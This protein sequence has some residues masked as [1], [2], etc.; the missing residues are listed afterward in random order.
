MNR[1]AFVMNTAVMTVTSLLLRSLGIVFRIFISNRVGAEGMG[2][3]QLV[4]SVYVLGTA[5][6]AAGLTTAVTR[7]TAEA[8]ARK[9]P[10]TA[11]RILR[12]SVGL[13]ILFGCVSAGLL[14]GFS[15]P[16]ARLIGDRRAASSLAVS[17]IALPFIGISSCLKGYFMARRRAA[18]PSM[19]QIAEQLT[20]I[21]GILLLL[22]LA[23]DCPLEEACRIIIIGDALS[24]TVCC[25]WLTAA[26]ALDRRKLRKASPQ[27]PP[28]VKRGLL[29]PLLAIAVPLTAGRYLTTGLRTVEN[30]LVP[31]MLTRF[32][33]SDARSLAQFGAVKGM[34]L[35]LLF[36]P[37]AFLVTLSNLLVPELSDAHALG[38]KRQ[39]TKLTGQSLHITMLGAM[40]IG[41]LFTVFGRELGQYLYHDETVGL[42]LQILGPLAPV[43]YL[44]TVATGLLRGLGEQVRSLWYSAADS[45]LRLSLIP[46]L[47][48][49]F[50]ITGF[51]FVMLLSNLLTAFLSTHR[52]LTVSH[53]PLEVG[54]WVLAPG[55][56]ASLA[57]GGYAALR[58]A[59]SFPGG[60]MELMAGMSAVTGV[61]LVLLP[62]L[63]GITSRDRQQLPRR[64]SHGAGI[65]QAEKKEQSSLQ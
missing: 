10:E 27:S 36:F 42:L 14:Y 48:P 28:R 22:R 8:L 50:G 39:V 15:Q 52:L 4:F 12:L 21:G 37:A 9:E 7:M 55:L 61:Y 53:T 43:M 41:C 26:Y 3:Y 35:P 17:G 49:R 34:A 38:Q 13:C 18:P 11:F 56:A 62:A 1:R 63:G 58:R 16:L 5:F 25:G 57:G 33:R 19:A 60:W 2:L 31:A 29:R 59:L 64:K 47:L 45:L 30:V 54:H 46:L 32:T 24:E 44:D 6:A 65:P 23:G 20:R 40:L 51:L